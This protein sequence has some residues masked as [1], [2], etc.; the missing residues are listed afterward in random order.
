MSAKSSSSTQDKKGIIAS[1][2]TGLHFWGLIVLILESVVLG[3]GL[4]LQGPDRTFLL[5][6]FVGLL[7]LLILVVAY[8]AATNPDALYAKDSVGTPT[9]AALFGLHLKTVFDGIVLNDKTKAQS[10]HWQHLMSRLRS[11]LP[12]YNKAQQRFC[13]NLA[14]AVKEA[15]GDLEP[16]AGGGVLKG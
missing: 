12:S 11:G 7:V 14:D 8:L 10:D 2:T 15:V 1:L 5:Y 4:S 13:K 16:E 9:F 6:A 3:L